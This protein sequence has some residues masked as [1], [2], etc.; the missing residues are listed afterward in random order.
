MTSWTSF[1]LLLEAQGTLDMA[2]T[3]SIP[4]PLNDLLQPAREET[5]FNSTR[6]S[7]LPKK[8]CLCRPW[9]SINLEREASRQY[10]V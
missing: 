2:F 1:Q 8:P 3:R 6:W 7:H 10:S 5:Q 4:T 9:I